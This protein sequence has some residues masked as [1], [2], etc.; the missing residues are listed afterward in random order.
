M[1]KLIECDNH[2]CRTWVGFFTTIQ[3][4]DFMYILWYPL[5]TK[6]EQQLLMLADKWCLLHFWHPVQHRSSTECLWSLNVSGENSTVTYDTN[7]VFSS[8]HT[9]PGH[10]KP[11]RRPPPL[12][13]TPGTCLQTHRSRTPAHRH[14]STALDPPGDCRTS[15]TDL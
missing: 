12:C 6:K 4:R 7:Q 14:G 3:R 9:H 1:C 11:L 13:R 10:C 2:L 5:S 8:W 15:R